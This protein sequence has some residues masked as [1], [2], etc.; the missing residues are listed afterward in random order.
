MGQLTCRCWCGRG[1]EHS[2]RAST[3][4]CAPFAPAAGRRFSPCALLPFS[5]TAQQPYN[6]RTLHHHQ[7]PVQRVTARKVLALPRRGGCLLRVPWGARAKQPP[8]RRTYYLPPLLAVMPTPQSHT[9]SSKC[10]AITWRQIKIF[11][12]D[13]P[14]SGEAIRWFKS[15]G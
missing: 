10:H 13:T 11:R 12:N 6:P 1:P 9:R 7:P 8:R 14:V 4:E 5:P 15:K 3:P 2:P